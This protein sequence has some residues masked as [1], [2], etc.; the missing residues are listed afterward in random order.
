MNQPKQRYLEAK[1]VHLGD[2][3]NIVQLHIEE[4]AAI[5][6][7]AH[8]A[9]C[10]RSPQATLKFLL[11]LVE[12]PL[13]YWDGNDGELVSPSWELEIPPIPYRLA[14]SLPPNMGHIACHFDT[15]SH[16]YGDVKLAPNVAEITRAL[17][18]RELVNV[19]IAPQAGMRNRHD[20]SLE[21]KF[22]IMASAELVIGI[23]DGLSHLALM[24]EAKT[25]VVHKPKHPVHL[26][27]AG[28]AV[29]LDYRIAPTAIDAILTGS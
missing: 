28:A 16:V 10:G 17:G 4:I 11:G 15:L 9:C 14:S 1:Y 21:E 8:C 5:G 23:D 19:G 13:F 25:I 20:A 12:S 29:L 18:K 3:V 6:A 2:L 26:F 27:Y 24:T 7:P 22:Q